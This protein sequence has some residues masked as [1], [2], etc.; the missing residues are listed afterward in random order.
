[1]SKQTGDINSN[2]YTVLLRD[3]EFCYSLSQE[4]THSNTEEHLLF[5][6]KQNR[7]SFSE[8]LP[9]TTHSERTMV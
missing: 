5:L 1:M 3:T 6:P 4:E 9:I 2:I 8:E 7:M